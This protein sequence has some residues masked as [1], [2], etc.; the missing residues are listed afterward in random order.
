MFLL[1]LW[2]QGSSSPKENATGCCSGLVEFQV[3]RRP[4]AD[5]LEVAVPGLVSVSST[6]A[7]VVLVWSPPKGTLGNAQCCEPFKGSVFC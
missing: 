5:E 7:S 2:L 3:Q 4:P 6:S 1:L